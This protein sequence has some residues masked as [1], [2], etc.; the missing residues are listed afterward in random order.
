MTRGHYD[1]RS[2]AGMSAD[3]LA[4]ALE[5]VGFDVGREFVM[6]RS[7]VD[8]RARP[9][10]DLGQIPELTAQRLT[11]VLSRAAEAGIVLP[12]DGDS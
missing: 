9:A 7:A 1:P 2:A 12:S 5:N 4:S 8:Y 3:L 6:L 10:V 11:I